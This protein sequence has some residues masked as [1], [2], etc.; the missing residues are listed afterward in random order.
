MAPSGKT[1][2]YVAKYFFWHLAKR[3]ILP[4]TMDVW[5]LRKVVIIGV[6]EMLCEYE[7]HA[8]ENEE[9]AKSF[10]IQQLDQTECAATSQ[11][12][13]WLVY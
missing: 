6:R 3:P 7:M 10:W 8:I 4:R 9:L 5:T 11:L 1:R 2:F 13:D 12:V